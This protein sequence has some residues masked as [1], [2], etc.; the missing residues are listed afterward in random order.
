MF[1]KKHKYVLS[2]NVPFSIQDAQICNQL[3]DRAQVYHRKDSARRSIAVERDS[4]VLCSR[5]ADD[6]VSYFGVEK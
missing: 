5:A 3:S 6:V 2:E 1:F 4:V